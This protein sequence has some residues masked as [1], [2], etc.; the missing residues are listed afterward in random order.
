M[1]RVHGEEF[2]LFEMFLAGLYLLIVFV[3]CW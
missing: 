3:F 1:A 2:T